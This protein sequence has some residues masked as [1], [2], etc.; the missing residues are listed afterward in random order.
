MSFLKGPS[1]KTLP[2]TRGWGF[3]MVKGVGKSEP[4]DT[5]R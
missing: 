1:T 3:F 2:L 4:D 5:G